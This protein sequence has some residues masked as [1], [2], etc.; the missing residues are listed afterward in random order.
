MDNGKAP[1]LASAIS[2]SVSLYAANDILRVLAPG[3][4]RCIALEGSD[5]ASL[6]VTP[7]ALRGAKL[8]DEKSNGIAG[9]AVEVSISDASTSGRFE[10]ARVSK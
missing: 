2:Q 9:P 4:W 3:G 8:V 5:G 6:Y 10:V 7:D 1:D